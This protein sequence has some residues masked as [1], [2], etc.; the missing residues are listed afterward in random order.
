MTN[1]IISV[2][3]GCSNNFWDNPEFNLT[4]KGKNIYILNQRLLKYYDNIT[5]IPDLR[6][7]IR[8]K[9]I[10]IYKFI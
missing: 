6:F 2:Y 1:T 7:N 9:K 4:R 3:L 10:N 8:I 5:L